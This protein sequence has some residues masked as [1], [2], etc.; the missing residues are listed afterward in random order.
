MP[1]LSIETLLQSFLLLCVHRPIL[2]CTTLSRGDFFNKKIYDSGGEGVDVS[3]HWEWWT[4]TAKFGEVFAVL[5]KNCKN[6][7]LKVSQEGFSHILRIVMEPCVHEVFLDV[8]I[9]I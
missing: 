8:K 9:K 2:Q 3:R 7:Q 6:G 4:G 5:V 1:K